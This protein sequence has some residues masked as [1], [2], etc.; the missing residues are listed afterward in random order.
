MATDFIPAD[1]AMLPNPPKLV[2]QAS[3]IEKTYLTAIPPNQE[4]LKNESG[5]LALATDNKTS[6]SVFQYDMQLKDCVFVGHTNTDLDSVAAA[7]G[8]AYL[9]K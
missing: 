2:R 3:A 6:H 7:I 9:F 1:P 4:L 8:A 5:A